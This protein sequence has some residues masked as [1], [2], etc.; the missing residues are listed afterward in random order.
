MK[1]LLI[2]AAIALFWSPLAWG[3]DSG[4]I[5]GTVMAEIGGIM[6]PL[7]HTH[8][9]A[10]PPDSDRPTNDGFTDS[11]GHYTLHLPFGGY[12]VRAEKMLFVPEWFDNV[13]ERPQAT[14]VHV[15][16]EN[17]PDNIDFV[18]GQQEQEGG[19]IGGRIIEAGT[20]HGIPNALVVATRL[21]EEP[22]T[23]ETHSGWHGQYA[24]PHLP[25]GS[26]VVAASREGFNPGQFPDT[27]EVNDNE[28]TGVDIYLEAVEPP[29][30]PDP[31]S[32]SGTVTDGVSDLPLEH[33]YVRADGGEWR[34]HFDTNTNAEGHYSFPELPP[35]TYHIFAFKM[36]YFP[37]EYPENIPI[38]GNDVEGIDLIMVP[39]EETGISGVVTDAANGQPIANA[40]IFATN[41]NNHWMHFTGRTGDDGAYFLRT[42][43]G[44]YVVEAVAMGYWRQEYPEHVNIEDGEVVDGINFA[45]SSFD[46]G[47]IAGIVTDS[48]GTPIAEAFVEAGKIGG[49]FMRHTRSDST[50]AYILE[51]LVPG[52]Y[53]IHAFHRDFGP[54]A[55]P[56]S[57]IVGDGQDVTGINI[58]LGVRIPP[59]EGTI[60]GLVTDD[61]TGAAI[62]HA[63]VMAIGHIDQWGHRQYI[64][65]RTFTDSTG[66]YLLE[67]LPAIPLKLFSG[68]RGYLGE[69]YDNV[70]RFSEATPVTPDAE[71]I[72]FALTARELGPR[73]LSGRVI[74]PDGMESDGLIL[75]A[76]I[77][78]EITDIIAAD[79]DGYYSFDE[80]EGAIYEV[81]A[82]SVY[83]DAELDDPVNA[84]Y[85]DVVD[86]DIQFSVTSADDGQT[87]PVATSLAQ[88]YPN[89]FNA[90]TLI[91]YNLARPGDVDLSV[92]NIVGQKVTTLVNGEF[93]AGSY[94]VTWDGTDASGR[95]VATGIYYYRLAT[96]GQTETMKMTML[97]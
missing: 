22:L 90:R 17:S 94:T 85:D 93:E 89:P 79:P 95:P 45:L 64:F 23:R 67:N 3:Q 58:V 28:I 61:S 65:R 43:S 48:A 6:V 57:V 86:A 55:Y 70:R 12:V 34:H 26:Y 72:N 11:T 8:V 76:L 20:D 30:P 39:F 2:L 27:L 1:K 74:M 47:S 46:F 80:V 83:G 88:N 38:E 63:L 56:D 29:P 41:V 87:L 91:S 50:G 42:H 13:F 33:V 31:G 49:H 4:S 96:G 60:S 9:L 37:A 18:L 53:R 25:P 24:F 32:I 66:N 15:T 36:G 97:K 21:G 75:Y 52:S 16:Q 44:E 59:A 5:S 51:E 68:A 62:G 82:S 19:F 71:N 81:Q 78:G 7:P 14:V 35:D 92:Y 73:A 84:I 40:T 54:G 77:N 69:F 10:F